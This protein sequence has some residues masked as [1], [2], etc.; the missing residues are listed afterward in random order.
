MNYNIA[1]IKKNLDLKLFIKYW[2]LL[3]I[4]FLFS[5]HSWLMQM[6]PWEKQ[7]LKCELD[8][9][10]IQIYDVPKNID[11]EINGWGSG[12]FTNNQY[13]GKNSFSLN[14]NGNQYSNSLTTIL[15]RYEYDFQIRVKKDNWGYEFGYTHLFSIPKK[16]QTLVDNNGKKFQ[17][18]SR[19]LYL[20]DIAYDGNENPEALWDCYD[21]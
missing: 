3:L 16:K 7:I 21:K 12:K 8:F 9:D 15:G 19:S 4:F 17:I 2:Y 1:Y 14:T 18:E 11:L 13:Y 6:F 5:Y 20:M 10:N